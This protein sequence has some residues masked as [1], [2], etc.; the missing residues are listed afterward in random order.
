MVTV[1]WTSVLEQLLPWLI[2]L[3]TVVV[4]TTG[5]AALLFYGE[6]EEEQR[7]TAAPRPCLDSDGRDES[8]QPSEPG[9]WAAPCDSHLTARA[10]SRV[11]ST[12]ST[13]SQRTTAT[14]A[15]PRSRLAVPGLKLLAS[16]IHRF[17]APLQFPAKLERIGVQGRALDL[18]AVLGLA[19]HAGSPTDID[20]KTRLVLLWRLGARVAAVRRL[21]DCTLPPCAVLR[22]T[23]IGGG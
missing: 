5:L 6:A 21:G 14:A 13:A 17:E 4:A 18:G 23:A 16:G 12:I 1:S 19:V 11:S 9:A 20:G 2:V 7:R 15:S 10:H 8:R 3:G 22:R